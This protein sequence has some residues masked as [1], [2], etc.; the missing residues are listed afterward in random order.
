M[1]RLSSVGLGTTVSS[2]RINERRVS[3]AALKKKQLVTT[4]P[5][6]KEKANLTWVSGNSSYNNW[7]Q[8]DALFSDNAFCKRG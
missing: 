3:T 1:T 5:K 7:Y 6:T 4:Q 8:L 2:R